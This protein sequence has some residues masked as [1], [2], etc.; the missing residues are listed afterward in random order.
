MTVNEKATASNLSVGADGK[1]PLCKTNTPSISD[2]QG[3]CNCPDGKSGCGTEE[4]QTVT[5]EELYD[6]AYPP[7]APVIDGLLYNGTY[8]YCGS[9]KGWKVVFYGAVRLPC[10]PWNTAV[11]LSVNTGDGAVSGFGGRLWKA[12]E[13]AVADVRNGEYGKS[14]FRNQVPFLKRRAGGVAHGICE[15]A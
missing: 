8:L 14:S 13:E 3:R 1:Q 5:M 4:L 2:L 11:G 12:S 7:K 6:T 15:R 9:A 10:E